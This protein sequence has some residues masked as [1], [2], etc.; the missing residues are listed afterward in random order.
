MATW[1]VA[2]LAA[3]KGRRMKSSQPKVLHLLS[4]RPMVWHVVDTARQLGLERMVAVVGQPSAP[5][6]ELLGDALEY[7]EQ[8]E[9]LGTGHALLQARPLL[10]GRA[11]QVLALNGDVPLILPDLLR[12]LVECHTAGRARLTFLS[13]DSGDPAG[14]GRV[15]RDAR[16]R[17]VGIIEDDRATPQEKA[18]REWNCGLY[19]FQGSWLWPH[20]AALPR[21]K[22]GEFLL[23]DLIAEAAAEEG[24][25]AVVSHDATQVL[26]I[27]NRLHLA[28][29]EAVLRQ[30][31]R[32]RV[33]L[34]GVTLLDP[35][36]TFIDTGVT[37]GQDTVV[38]PNSTVGGS[39]VIGKDC[40]IGPSSIIVD[41]TLGDR[42]RVVASVVEGA[43][44]GEG[45]EVGPFSH[46]R[47]E[48]YL[49]DGVHLGN[50]AE[51]KKSRLG[52]NTRMGHFSYIG[53]AD[54]G[55]EVNIGAGT[56]TCNF[57]GLNKYR[58][59]IGA[60]AF[61][62]SDTMLVAPVEVGEGAVTGAG[63]VVNRDVPPGALAVG[64]PARLR[65]R[66]QM[67]SPSGRGGKSGQQA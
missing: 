37:I 33:M 28:Q 54:V 38:Y 16:G 14:L 17:V 67:R 66:G 55:A 65:R 3:G 59:L 45:V 22:N 49:E 43:T 4:G 53:D 52:R 21:S 61:I 20:L 50:F 2:I 36:S 27:N 12:Q 51:V 63:S 48:S 35:P 29:A 23:T 42:C 6:R 44:L 64:A 57:D 60:G 15:L 7:A 26:G 41:S 18:I 46:V 11:E 13:C 30:R 47:P 39:S 32:E 10:E 34:G 25:K 56:I 19:A 31:I 1:G 24:V 40:H 9:P 5:F 8:A 58:T 62:G